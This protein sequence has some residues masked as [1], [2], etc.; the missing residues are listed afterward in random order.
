MSDVNAN[1]SAAER[2]RQWRQKNID[3]VK[4]RIQCVC[5]STYTYINKCNHLRT[6]KHQ[7]YLSLQ[8]ELENLRKELEEARA[9]NKHN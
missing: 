4:S 9:I 7:R 5:G 8:S 2:V 6:Q 3:M 1:Q